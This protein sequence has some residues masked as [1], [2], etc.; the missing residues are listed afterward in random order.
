VAYARK[1]LDLI[2]DY[3][4]PEQ[5]KQPLPQDERSGFYYPLNLVAAGYQEWKATGRYPDPEELSKRLNTRFKGDIDYL[6]DS[7]EKLRPKPKDKPDG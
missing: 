3:H 5:R 6:S 4:H 1:I 7:I 2:H